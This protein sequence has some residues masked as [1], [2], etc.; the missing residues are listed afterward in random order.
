MRNVPG[1]VTWDQINEGLMNHI[2]KF[3]LVLKVVQSQR[4]ILKRAGLDEAFV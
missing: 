1:K 3:R 2:N 4:Q